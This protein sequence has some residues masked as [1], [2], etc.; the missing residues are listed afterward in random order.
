MKITIGSGNN[1]KSVVVATGKEFRKADY[2]E[3][4]K[5]VRNFCGLAGI[6]F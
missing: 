4:R 6:K 5:F 3:R 1:R 2:H